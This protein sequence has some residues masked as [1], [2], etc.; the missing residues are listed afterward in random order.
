MTN[1]VMQGYKITKKIARLLDTCIRNALLLT[2]LSAN[3]G[4]SLSYCPNIYIYI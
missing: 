4:I 1:L 2:L 3:T